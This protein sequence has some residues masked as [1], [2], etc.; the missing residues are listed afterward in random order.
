[1]ESRNV[2]KL[3][4]ICDG[5]YTSHKCN[6]HFNNLFQSVP[7]SSSDFHRKQFSFIYDN[8]H[9]M[10]SIQWLKITYALGTLFIF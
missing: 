9:D 8:D 5:S 6:H 7:Y 1:M 2:K 4:V 3:K 10:L